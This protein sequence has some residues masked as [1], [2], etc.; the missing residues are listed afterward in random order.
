MLP[1]HISVRPQATKWGAWQSLYKQNIITFTPHCATR[2]AYRTTITGFVIS[3]PR[4][5]QSLIRIPRF[6]SFGEKVWET[7]QSVM[8]DAELEEASQAANTSDG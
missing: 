1:H 7:G 8:A 4:L 5:D 6:I 2:A 3:G